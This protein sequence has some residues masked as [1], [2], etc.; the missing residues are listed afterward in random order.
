MRISCASLFLW[1]YT[2][3]EI[4]GILLDAGI[5]SVEFWAE[6]PGFWMN[7]NDMANTLILEET[8]SM[9]PDGC[10]LHAPVM[11]L[12]PSS[13]NENVCEVTIKETLWALELAGKIGARA[14][15]IHPGRRTVNRPPLEEDWQKFERY[16][17]ICTK[18]ADALDIRLALENSMPSVSS[19]CSS[20]DEM[21]AVLDKFQSIYFTF[22]VVHAF[23]ESPE[24]AISFVE[25]LGARITNVHAG[26]PHDGKPHYPLHMKDNMRGILM[27][28]RDTGY[29]GDLTIEID[30][31]VYGRQLSKEDKTKELEAE[32][33]YLEG[34]F[35]A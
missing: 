24:N 28:L 5:R 13:I 4:M 9:M 20:P 29:D 32:R 6:T 16:L 31:K 14:V 1:E 8:L 15:T 34:I 12:N 27:A 33:K 26:A 3:P 18:R 30:D 21:T 10:T 7:R 22:D 19:M 23:I 17:G 11:D 35:G 25:Q 2:L